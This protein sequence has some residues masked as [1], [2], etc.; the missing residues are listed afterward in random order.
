[1]TNTDSS[2]RV[3]GVLEVSLT[4]SCNYSCSWCNQRQDIDSP[5]EDM[6]DGKR[7]IVSND[8]R[9]GCEWIEGLNGFPCKADYCTLIFSGGEPSLHPDFFEIVSQVKGFKS[10]LL[11]TNL[12][13]DVEKLIRACRAEG[14]TVIVQPSFQFEFADFAVF[15]EKLKALRREKFLSNFIPVSIVDLP[16]RV[17]PKQ[18]RRRFE[19]EGFLASLYRFEGSYKGTF[20]YAPPELFGGSSQMQAVLCACSCR[21]VKPNGDVVFCQTDTFVEDSPTLGNICDQR[22]QEI[23]SQRRCERMGKCHVSASSWTEILDPDSKALL[24][25]GKNFRLYKPVN[26]LRCFLVSRNFSGLAYV[27]RA[28]NKIQRLRGRNRQANLG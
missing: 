26:R 27:K 28:V 11:V 9:R 8:L 22:Y 7:R 15:L 24:W 12:S 17:E 3:C 16:D 10:K 20:D 1:M 14:S 18:F 5:M 2:R 23:P 4:R 19:E 25:R 21:L 6:R 13:F